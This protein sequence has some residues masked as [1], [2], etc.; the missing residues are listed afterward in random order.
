MNMSTSINL[1]KTNL[2][3]E[4]SGYDINGNRVIKLSFPNSRGFS[5]Q[6]G[7]GLPKS[8]SILRGLKT[9]KDMLTVDKKDLIVISKEV[10][11]YIK[12]YGSDTQK[13]KLKIFKS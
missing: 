10:S 8:Y 4:G 3:L 2:Y 9:H 5:I 11:G 7:S 6:M 1:P 13:K 12:K